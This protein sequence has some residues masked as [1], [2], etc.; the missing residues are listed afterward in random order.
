MTIF[1]GSDA[2]D[3]QEHMPSIGIDAGVEAGL[4]KLVEAVGTYPLT[5][6]TKAV[7][8][9][10]EPGD[11]GMSLGYAWFKSGYVLPRHSH[12]ADCLYY[13]LG[14]E[15]H[16]GSQTLR[17]GDGVFIPADAGYTYEAGPNGVEV[18]EFRNATQFHLMFQGNDEAHW[19]RI[20]SVLKNNCPKWEGEPP[21][22]GGL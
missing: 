6:G 20:A 10:K 15:L 18:L 13:V 7:L 2:R 8:L 12:N 9:F 11:R 14:G 16:M 21:P 17:K 5:S 4:G 19:D 3:V 22:V 1:R